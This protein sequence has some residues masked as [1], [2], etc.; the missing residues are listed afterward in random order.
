MGSGWQAQ[1]GPKRA[2]FLRNIRNQ[3][4]VDGTMDDNTGYAESDAAEPNGA[5][6]Y[7]IQL[8]TLSPG[9]WGTFMYVGGQTPAPTS[10][11]SW[12]TDNVPLP[13]GDWDG[14]YWSQ[15]QHS[16]ASNDH[17]LNPPAGE[18]TAIRFGVRSA[19]DHV[20]DIRF[21]VAIERA[22]RTLATARSSSWGRRC[23]I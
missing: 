7:T 4:A 9:D 14:T 8:H 17:R 21:N 10:I 22:L 3:A 1:A 20:E 11:A 12:L 15:V 16:R 19:V 23:N 5:N 6:P 13:K 18:N 2:A